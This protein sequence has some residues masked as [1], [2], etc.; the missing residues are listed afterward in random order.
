MT[1]S[2]S[3]KHVFL[4]EMTIGVKQ[5]YLFRGQSSGKGLLDVDSLNALLAE[6]SSTLKKD[7]VVNLNKFVANDQV[8]GKVIRQSSLLNFRCENATKDDFSTSHYFLQEREL[9]R[10]KRRCG[11]FTTKTSLDIRSFVD[12]LR[13]VDW[14]RF[15]YISEAHEKAANSSRSLYMSILN[16]FH[17]HSL[18]TINCT[19]SCDTVLDILSILR[20]DETFF[21]PDLNRLEC[22][23]IAHACENDKGQICARLAKISTFQR[24]CTLL[25]KLKY[26]FSIPSFTSNTLV[27][28]KLLRKE[29]NLSNAEVDNTKVV[30]YLRKELYLVREKVEQYS[31]EINDGIRWISL[32]HKVPNKANARHYCISYAFDK[33]YNVGYQRLQMF[34]VFSFRRWKTLTAIVVQGE[35][36]RQI[37]TIKSTFF[38]FKT[39]YCRLRRVYKNSFT[40][41]LKKTAIIRRMTFL[42]SIVKIQKVYRGATSRTKSKWH[43]CRESTA[44][45]VI[46]SKYRMKKAI[47]QAKVMKQTIVIEL[48]MT[49]LQTLWRR[50]KCQMDYQQVLFEWKASVIIQ[51]AYRIRRARFELRRQITKTRAIKII[52]S[53]VRLLNA[54]EYKRSLKDAY[55]IIQRFA[56][57]FLAQK[58]LKARRLYLRKVLYT[59][60]I[61]SFW[62]GRRERI[63]INDLKTKRIYAA[64]LINLVCYKYLA[65]AKRKSI[66]ACTIQ[67]SIRKSKR[68]RQN[69]ASR[70]IQRLYRRIR[71]QDTI[72]RSKFRDATIK[73]QCAF[74]VWKAHIEVNTIRS[75][76]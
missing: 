25:W 70:I 60:S 32:N 59:I 21:I 8:L 58:E 27:A 52:Q 57:G 35:E 64:K 11:S 72:S 62:R 30:D 40:L 56:H 65:L 71:H 16:L 61:Q 13:F 63:I 10:N 2:R 23:T 31:N 12:G 47:E 50:N 26:N 41:L 75:A 34:V 69:N 37:T 45:V 5:N 42:T 24:A 73:I 17:E 44:A 67:K 53:R 55:L 46:Q 39:L 36:I 76:Q 43:Y 20:K 33:I 19:I 51:C 74:R 3:P 28:N 29:A 9:L 6:K 7:S 14:Q 68:S 4:Y 22:Q 54:I 18:R 48:G 15:N 66:A 1:H 38:F 49:K